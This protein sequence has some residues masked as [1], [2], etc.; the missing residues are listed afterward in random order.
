LNSIIKKLMLG[1]KDKYIN[2]KSEFIKIMQVKFRE[3]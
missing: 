1:D 3:I 2:K